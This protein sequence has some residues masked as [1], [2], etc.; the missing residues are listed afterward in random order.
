MENK[1]LTTNKEDTTP[2]DSYSVF[3]WAFSVIIGF[4]KF[5]AV[6][7]FGIYYAAVFVFMMGALSYTVETIMI[8]RE[9]ARNNIPKMT[10]NQMTK[11]WVSALSVISTVIF[12]LV[13]NQMGVSYYSYP[14]AVFFISFAIFSNGLVLHKFYFKQAGMF[15]LIASVGMFGAFLY[16]GGDV[17]N[18][19]ER[20]ISA[21]VSGGAYFYIAVMIEG[22]KK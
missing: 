18:H 13:F 20:Y 1:T 5:E 11:K 2:H 17:F 14:T 8:F 21:V 9:N 22:L 6:L 3:T 4:Y 12:V 10:H 7:E 19:H 16:F 15:G